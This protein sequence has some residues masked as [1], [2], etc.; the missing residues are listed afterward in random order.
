MIQLETTM[1]T[2]DVKPGSR[3]HDLLELRGNAAGTSEVRRIAALRGD[4]DGSLLGRAIAAW[5]PERLNA[6]LEKAF[7]VD[8]FAL[9][10]KAWS[11]IAKVRDAI[12]KS[13]GP[14]P[15]AASVP[16]LKH[17]IDAKV[18]PRLVLSVEG[19]DWCDVEFELKLALALESAELELFDGA[20]RAVR[21]GKVTGSVTL[22]CQGVPVES[23]RR[24]LRFESG[25]V[26]D[27]P[28]LGGQR[29]SRASPATTTP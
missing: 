4:V 9:M 1:S 28:I 12:K 10:A 8:P 25:Y 22:A 27:P 14:P 5:T 23:F 26:F 2:V 15:A 3:M 21:L 20:L 11:Q 16:L 7:D 13:L 24:D 29:V 18:R 19:V 6:D 17:D